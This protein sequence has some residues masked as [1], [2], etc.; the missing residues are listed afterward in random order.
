MNN[1]VHDDRHFNA[2]DTPANFNVNAE[3]H[4]DR[5]LLDKELLR[6]LLDNAR[7]LNKWERRFVRSFKSKLK[8]RKFRLTPKQRIKAQEIYA[9]RVGGDE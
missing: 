7:N 6:T 2:D 8:R 5:R 4:K 1:L 3:D 9:E